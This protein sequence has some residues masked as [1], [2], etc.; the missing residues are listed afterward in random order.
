[1]RGTG[2]IWKQLLRILRITP[3]HA[4]NSYYYVG[5]NFYQKDHPRACG[6]QRGIYEFQQD[7]V[8]SPPRM[9]G[10]AAHVRC[11]FPSLGITPAHAGNRRCCSG[12]P[13]GSRDHPRACGEQNLV[14][15]MLPDIEGSPPRMRG[16]DT[17]YVKTNGASGITPAHAGNSLQPHSFDL[18]LWDHPRACGEQC[19]IIINRHCFKGSPPRMRGTD[20]ATIKYFGIS[21][22]TP[23]HAGN[24]MTERTSLYHTKDHPR[25]C[26]EQQ[27][28]TA[29]DTQQQG[30]PP[31]MR[32][33]VL[34]PRHAYAGM[35]ITPAHAGNRLNRSRIS[36]LSILILCHFHSVY[37][38]PDKCSRNLPT[39][40][41]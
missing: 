3:A 24:R 2:N 23:A 27:Q 14:K 39:L 30:S 35:R 21:G 5:K 17:G 1:M 4:G 37:N 13:A 28:T 38:R 25:A 41:A 32:G 10:T 15:P 22:I 11:S 18:L 16:T 26:G 33:T 31:R 34:H 12:S 36:V 8:G 19:E 20:N 40:C 29:P 6:E 7:E 9:R